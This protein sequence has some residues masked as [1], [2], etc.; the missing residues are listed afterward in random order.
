M[1]DGTAV[2]AVTLDCDNLETVVAFWKDLLDLEEEERFPGGVLLSPMG[3]GGPR[4]A[5][6]QVPERK[7]TKNRMHHDLTADD[8]QA[9]VARVLQMGGSRLADHE[10]KILRWTVMADPEGNEFCIAPRS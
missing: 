1:T 6:Q 5:F 7:A 8:R 9:V 2:F 4:L 3:D 10:G